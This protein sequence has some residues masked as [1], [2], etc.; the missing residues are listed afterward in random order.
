MGWVVRSWH[1]CRNGAVEVLRYAQ[2][3]GVGRGRREEKGITQGTQRAEST[4]DTEKS[5][6]LHYELP[7]IRSSPV[8]MTE[9]GRGKQKRENG[10]RVGWMGC[11][12]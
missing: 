9:R 8:G 12:V 3:D 6:S 2:D 10:K 1:G 5:R 11:G 7:E 4:E